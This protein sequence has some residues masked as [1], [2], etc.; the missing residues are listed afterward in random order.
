MQII[1]AVFIFFICSHNAIFS[2]N[3][4]DFEILPNDD[5]SVTILNYRGA[6]KNVVIPPAILNLPVTKIEGRA[7]S[8]RGLTSVRIPNSVLYINEHAFSNNQLTGVELPASLIG[9]E[10]HAF[11]RNRIGAVSLPPALGYIGKYAFAEN[12]LTSIIIPDNVTVIGEKSFADN[13]LQTIQLGRKV[14]YIGKHA[15][16]YN[17]ALSITLPD[18]VAYLG[19]G[20]FGGGP[21]S[22]TIGSNVF[23]DSKDG[24]LDYYDEED[25]Y[26]SEKFIDTEM[27]GDW[28]YPLRKLYNANNR[29][30]GTYAYFND[31]SE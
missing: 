9:I 11:Y 14:S 25:R 30:A 20:A 7:F 28:V 22:I 1:I 13:Q 27:G 2:Q 29:R 18:S 21:R 6:I 24:G 8:D 15:F 12:R 23:V 5:G 17:R 26:R 3:I 16:L 4:S 19:F 10:D 31:N